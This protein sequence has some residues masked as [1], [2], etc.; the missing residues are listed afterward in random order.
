MRGERDR[1]VEEGKS[2]RQAITA[3]EQD[4]QVLKAILWNQFQTSLKACFSWVPCTA[5]GC[6][7]AG[8]GGGSCD[9]ETVLPKATAEFSFKRRGMNYL[10][11]VHLSQLV[12][13][14]IPTVCL[15]VTLSIM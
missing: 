13:Q 15:C 5:L 4:K 3:L 10:I 6:K 7:A 8:I 9:T 12:Q 1:A 14:G 2:L 11:N